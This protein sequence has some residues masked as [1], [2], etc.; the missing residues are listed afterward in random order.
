MPFPAFTSSQCRSAFRCPAVASSTVCMIPYA[1]QFVN[2]YF[3]LFLRLLASGSDAVRFSELFGVV[4]SA[5]F[6]YSVLFHNYNYFSARGK[7]NGDL[8]FF[9]MPMNFSVYLQYVFSVLYV[10][11]ETFQC[12][13]EIFETGPNDYRNVS[14]YT[15][16]VFTFTPLKRLPAFSNICLVCKMSLCTVGRTFHYLRPFPRRELIGCSNFLPHYYF[17]PFPF[18]CLIF[19]IFSARSRIQT[20][21][22]H[23]YVKQNIPQS[24]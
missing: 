17:H 14:Y 16:K 3:S 22:R 2:M 20:N 6:Q 5:L 10:L 8:S 19:P 23:F 7:E 15:V 12:F 13:S 1:A 4:F 9:D 21:S 11:F 18:S 24:A